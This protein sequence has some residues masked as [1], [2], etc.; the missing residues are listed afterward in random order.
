MPT[1][2]P[3][4]PV[5]PPL[6]ELRSWLRGSICRFRSA[7]QFAPVCHLEV[8]AAITADAATASLA[9]SAAAHSAETH[10]L[11]AEKILTGILADGRVSAEE[12]PALRRAVRLVHRSAEIDHDIAERASLPPI[13]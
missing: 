5:I 9:L 10:D 11:E 1:A 4:P 7:R 6:A 8:A 13:A 2:L 3:L 12:L